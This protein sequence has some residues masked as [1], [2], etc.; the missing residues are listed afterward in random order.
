MSHI[1]TEEIGALI[2]N[3]TKQANTLDLVNNT[4]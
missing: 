2:E 4:V 3:M 1:Q